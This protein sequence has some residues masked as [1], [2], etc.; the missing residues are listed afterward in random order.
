ME[1][2]T[3]ITLRQ[4]HLLLSSKEVSSV[5]LTRAH[6]DR[7]EQVEEQ[8]K[9]FITLTPELALQQAQ[10]ADHRIA[11]G[12]ATPLTGVPVQI[13]DVMC[14]QGVRTT[15]GSRMLQDYVPVYNAHVVGRLLSAGAVMVGKGNMDEF[16][17]GS[18]C[19][20]SYFYPAKNPWD[21][22]RVPGGSSGGAGA[23]VAARESVYALG[24][25][26]GGSIRQPASMCGVVGL[27]PT[28]GLVSRYGLVAYASSLDQIG[29]ITKD[30]T[31]SSVVLSVIAGH[32]PRDSTSL[33]QDSIDHATGRGSDLYSSPIAR[34]PSSTP[35]G[36]GG[37]NG[38]IR[39]GV[40]QE[41]F[42]EGVEEGVDQAVRNAL[43]VLGGLGASIEP[44]SLPATKYA[45]AC[46]YMI[47]PA[48]CS[49][50]LARYDGVKY[51]HSFRDTGDMWAAMER[52]R[53]EGFGPEVRRRIMLG[54]Y[55]LSAGYYDAY[56][57]KAQQA[58]TLIQQDFDRVFQQVDALVTPT[59]PLVAF[60][61]GEKITDPVQMYLMDVC[62]VPANIAGLPG[63]SVPCGFSQGLPVGM[64]LMGPHLSE[65]T[66]LKI[67]YAYEQATEWHKMG[68]E[69]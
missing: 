40:P 35:L 41:Y 22:G 51:G 3:R 61:L 34:T 6:L 29:P 15:C 13:K 46:Y 54:T 23:A 24:S 28:Y 7:I 26:T 19:E 64:Q 17:M 69:L 21:L 38:A 59:S 56:Y 30:V 58:R 18:S 1:D 66:L 57:L 49:A 25:D 45:L 44:V 27:K 10:A 14:T 31:D 36:E 47:A 8:V 50:N 55:A 5:E 4:A 20:N 68:P 63:I 32:D 67:A 11:A 9:S 12:E 48:E 43:G 39:L 33:P 52:T 2:L 62:T 16:A 53:Q 37:Q 60:R 42:E 65:V